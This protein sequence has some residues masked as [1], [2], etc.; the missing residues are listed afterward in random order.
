M[1]HIIISIST[2]RTR[3]AKI[4]LAVKRRSSAGWYEARVERPSRVSVELN[5]HRVARTIRIQ[6]RV[7]VR[8]RAKS[9][10]HDR[11]AGISDARLQSQSI[12]YFVVYFERERPRPDRIEIRIVR[13]IENRRDEVRSAPRHPE[14]ALARKAVNRVPA[15]GFVHRQPVFAALESE[16]CAGD[17]A[18]PR[19]ENRDSAAMRM[20]APCVRIGRPRDDVER[21]SAVAETLASR[22]RHNH[23][24]LA[25]RLKRNEFHVMV[26]A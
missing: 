17:A 7:K 6:R 13:G 9:K 3:R 8:M 23:S 2:K 26:L 4:V 20:L 1:E 24:P 16:A 15:S 25:L 11:V 14:G 12:T 21:T 10:R 19:K 22:G 5:Q 18:R